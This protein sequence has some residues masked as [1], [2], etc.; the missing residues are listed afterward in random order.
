MS[1]PRDRV[2]LAFKA[3]MRAVMPRPWSPD[4]PTVCPRCG[5]TFRSGDCSVPG[6][7]GKAILARL[8]ADSCIN[9]ASRECGAKIEA[10]A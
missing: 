8:T 4:D 1:R 6:Q 5:Q 3:A 9:P 2:P 10:A 7:D